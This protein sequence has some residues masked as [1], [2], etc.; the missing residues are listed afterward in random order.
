MKFD[1]IDTLN[2]NEEIKDKPLDYFHDFFSE[3]WRAAS[4]SYQAAAKL[5]LYDTVSV[6]GLKITRVE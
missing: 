6:C 2:R 1:I 4:E 3:Q 5:H